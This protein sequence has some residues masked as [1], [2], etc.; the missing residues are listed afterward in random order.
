MSKRSK[1]NTLSLSF[2]F[3]MLAAS[4]AGIRER[5]QYKT[6]A[7]GSRACGYRS[8]VAFLLICA[9]LLMSKQQNGG[10]GLYPQ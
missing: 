1:A 3:G 7:T 4:D 10:T 9:F 2:V 6:A 8:T 5:F